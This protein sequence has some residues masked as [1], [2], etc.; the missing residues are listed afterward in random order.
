M[1]NYDHTSDGRRSFLK[2]LG[3]LG[4][5][6]GGAT[7]QAAA[8]R[9]DRVYRAGAARYP[10]TPRSF[11]Q[12]LFLAG[13]GGPGS[14]QASGSYGGG[15]S[16]RALAVSSK[17][18][19]VAFVTIDTVGMGNK[20]IRAI[21][22]DARTRLAG[23]AENL[24]EFSILVGSTHSHSGPDFQGLW[25]G[26]SSQYLDYVVSQ[27][28]KA[29]ANAV[30]S[31]APARL[32]VGET[33]IAD[34]LLNNRRGRE[35]PDGSDY[36]DQT[37]TTLQFE[38]KPHRGNRSKR[39]KETIATVINF[40]SNPVLV[41]SDNLEVG[42]DFV[43]SLE[44]EIEDKYGGTAIYFN[45]AQGDISLH[46]PDGEPKERA[47]EFG[48]LAADEAVSAIAESKPVPHALFVDST[49]ATIPQDNPAFD[50]LYINGLFSEY[51]D[52]NEFTTV[53][54]G[55]TKYDVP[56]NITTPV[57]RVSFGRGNA[58]LQTVTIPGEALTELGVDT[59]EKIGGRTQALW[60]LTQNT[61]G[62]IIPADDWENPPNNDP[63]EESV[64]FGPETAPIYRDAVDR[65]F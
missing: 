42:P 59:R 52:W 7:T 38:E 23:E 4:L 54:L 24:D 31:M 51:Y 53:N 14:R 35:D 43:R 57:T 63:Y 21:R 17:G 13:F 48:K 9:S 39:G 1:T 65:L 34:Y 64:S 58:S 30:R 49:I 28:G 15:I 8:K 41:G 10:V 18:E 32:F 40:A 11:N 37:L 56:K 50:Q 45:S 55:G 61:L 46:R 62:Y 36:T 60:G 12:R 44:K 22:Q 5:I 16:A 29:V 47:E 26:V 6:G 20:V 25:G 2:S 33:Q 27:A 3:A 19:I